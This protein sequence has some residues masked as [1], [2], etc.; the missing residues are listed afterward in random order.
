MLDKVC[1]SLTEE[2]DD[3]VLRKRGGRY[4]E[5]RIFLMLEVIDLDCIQ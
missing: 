3:K 2:R 1:T 5:I 4:I